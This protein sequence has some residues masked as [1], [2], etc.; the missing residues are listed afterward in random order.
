MAR[1][2]CHTGAPTVRDI[3][4]SFFIVGCM[5]FGGPA[6]HIGYLREEFVSKKQWVTEQAFSDLL[7]LCQ[8]LPGPGSTQLV[9]AIGTVC[10]GRIGGLAAFMGF[11]LPASVLMI[12]FGY[13]FLEYENT[14]NQDW[15]RGFTIA[16]VA[17]VARAVAQMA[18]VL[19][20]DF[21]S[22]FIAIVIIVGLLVWPSLFTQISAIA[23]GGLAG[24]L[25][26]R[27]KT[28]LE[29]FQPIRTVSE[30]FAVTNLSVFVFLL[31]GMPI[32]GSV[33]SLPDIF[34]VFEG[35]FRSG[36]L[37]FGGG[38][39]VLPLLEAEVV[40]NGWLAQDAFFS[41]Y[42]VMQAL[43]GPVF[44]F[45]GYIGT[46]MSPAPNGLLGGFICLVA[47]F[48]P[49]TLLIWGVLPYW[50][51]FSNNLRIGS[52]VS[53]INAAVVGLLAAAL[54]DPIWGNAISGKT[55]I[56]IALIAF[57]ALQLK[58][59]PIWLVVMG[60]AVAAGTVAAL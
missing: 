17:V 33:V 24:F 5:A 50:A 34:E 54:Y 19:C 3:F 36:S 29:K 56:A 57:C 40:P 41:G 20:P 21:R 43:P 13:G 42:G 38:H 32:F 14:F 28:T 39:V 49:G 2:M 10:R 16:V 6:A 26:R 59:I 31:L 15:Y 23:A 44:A 12:G 48:L 30:T 47:L 55:D 22:R 53:G 45:A 18:P 60:C 1:T 11:L 51:R 25:W 7:A 8:F 46:V 4:Q 35:L 52:I 9:I 37:V 58:K 27:N